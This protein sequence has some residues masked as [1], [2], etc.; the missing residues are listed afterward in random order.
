[1]NHEDVFGEDPQNV[2]KLH[3]ALRPFVHEESEGL[4]WTVLKHPLIFQVPFMSWKM[5]N[6]G[7]E[8]KKKYL[9]ELLDA[10]NYHSALWVYER[11]YRLYTLL[12]WIREGVIPQEEQAEMLADVWRDTEFPMRHHDLEELLEIYRDVGFHHDYEEEEPDLS[13]PVQIFRGVANE[14]DWEGMSWTT[15]R[16]VALKFAKRWSHYGPGF[17]FSAVVHPDDILALYRGRGE[18]EVIVDPAQLEQVEIDEEL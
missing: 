12:E 15:S 14:E 6:D 8:A 11:P 16:K 18:D 5:A 3:P 1:M 10:G 7:F 2:E 13:G 4:G 9:R 17:V